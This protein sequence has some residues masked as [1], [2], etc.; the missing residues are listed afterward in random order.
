MMKNATEHM[1]AA[2]QIF[3]AKAMLGLSETGSSENTVLPWVE[4]DEKETLNEESTQQ[5]TGQ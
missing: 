4:A 3:L 2:V 1:N 5:P